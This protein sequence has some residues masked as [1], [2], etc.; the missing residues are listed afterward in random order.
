MWEFITNA[1][2]LSGGSSGGSSG[3]IGLGQINGTINTI[4]SGYN[5]YK[6]FNNV[7][8]T[9]QKEAQLE[10]MAQ[11]QAY[12]QENMANANTH[13]FN[14]LTSANRLA[15]EQMRL[16][17]ELNLQSM[18]KQFG[19][20]AYLSNLGRS[21]VQAR[22]NGLQPPGT[23]SGGSVSA[24]SPSA[25]MPSA[26]SAAMATVTPGSVSPGRYQPLDPTAM[27]RN[28]ADAQKTKSEKE[29]VDIT[30]K[31]RL[32]QNLASL[33]VTISE[34][35]KN[36]SQSRNYDANT[37]Y[38][39]KNLEN[40][41]R[42]LNARLNALDAG[43]E[44]DRKLGDAATKNAET[45]ARQQESYQK[46]VDEVIR[47]NKEIEP[48][49][50]M[51]AVTQRY[52]AQTGRMQVNLNAEKLTSEISYLNAK[53]DREGAEAVQKQI[54]NKHWREKVL[55]EIGAKEALQKA[56]EEE[57]KLTGKKVE[58]YETQMAFDMAKELVNSAI[59]AVDAGVPF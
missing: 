15:Q 36:M 2:G 12:N 27:Y 49:M 1:L 59:K 40:Y 16:N 10:L 7:D 23:A 56:A 50:R 9:R 41:E 6:D 54:E 25:P 26:P 11:Q 58:W 45:A 21:I 33:Q 3:G 39:L 34:Y 38:T 8:I 55:A 22:Q 13:Q 48:I 18:D 46:S 5:L 24:L 43:A 4:Q 30:N 17:H 37:D 29:G 28:I 57:A 14:M 44:K 20:N 53:A 42:E 52:A 32:A 35:K 31:T 19:Y 51:N 47:H